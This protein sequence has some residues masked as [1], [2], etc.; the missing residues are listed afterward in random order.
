MQKYKRRYKL[1]SYNS[2]FELL[3][4]VPEGFLEGVA[5][6]LMGLL[7]FVPLNPLHDGNPY[8]WLL[9]ICTIGVFGVLFASVSICKD[10]SFYKKDLFGIWIKTR[11]LWVGLLCMLLW[12]VGATLASTNIRLSW[13]GYRAEGLA[14]Y[15]TYAL[16]TVI[17]CGLHTKKGIKLVLELFVGASAIIAGMVGIGNATLLS[18][19][20]MQCHTGPFFNQ[21]HYGYYLCM[22]LLGAIVLAVG[23]SKEWQQ[24]K[25][26][27]YDYVLE[28]L[29]L[30]EVILISNALVLCRSLG[31]LLGVLI[32]LV[33]YTILI[34]CLYPTKLK[35]LLCLNALFAVILIGANTGHWNLRQ[36]VV[37]LNKDIEALSTATLQSCQNIGSGRGKLWINGIKFA[38]ERPLFG[39]GPDNL[40]YLYE[41]LGISNDRPHN[42][43]I[44]FAASLGIPA[45]LFYVGGLFVHLWSFIKGIKQLSPLTIGLY[46]IV[47]GYL[48]SSLFGN[49]MFY[50][51]P[52]FFM[53]LALSYNSIKGEK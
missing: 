48:V 44:Q 51:T 41:A 30:I 25:K 2:L 13:E 46:V 40:G 34:A 11:G 45:M 23:D 3:T 1:K 53:I 20:H 27:K 14:T 6:V 32:A 31:P 9:D 8:K 50:T 18:Y 15:T 4:D 38:L 39:Y 35:K 26:I 29:H 52:Y 5:I 43:L 7:C 47:G 16:I 22:T 21:N 42:E 37:T 36:E 12:S 17:A 24:H 19:F 10:I 28:I 49:T 33:A